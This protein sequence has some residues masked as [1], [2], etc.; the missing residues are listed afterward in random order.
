MLTGSFSG[1]P[2]CSM[3]SSSSYYHATLNIS[4]TPKP[5][6]KPTPKSTPKSSSRMSTLTLKSHE[7]SDPSKVLIHQ[8]VCFQLML[9]KLVMLSMD[10]SKS[11]WTSQKLAIQTQ[12]VWW[13][14][15]IFLPF[16][17]RTAWIHLG[18]LSIKLRHP[19][20]VILFRSS[21]TLGQNSSQWHLHQ[22]PVFLSKH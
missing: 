4:P 17:T 12:Q 22:F 1:C 18:M 19:L 13:L 10:K 6:S 2:C 9:V 14:S 16:I 7:S 3:Y 11:Q 8:V 21:G 15:Y 20:L 5:N